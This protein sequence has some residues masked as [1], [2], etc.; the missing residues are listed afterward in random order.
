MKS[1]VHFSS[2]LK[3]QGYSL[4]ASSVMCSP[5]EIWYQVV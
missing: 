4:K 5:D 2:M 3:G 1:P